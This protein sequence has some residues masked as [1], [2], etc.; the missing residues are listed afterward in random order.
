M[1]LYFCVFQ[2]NLPVSFKFHCFNLKT[3]T[4]FIFKTYN[5]CPVLE[6]NSPCKNIFLLVFGKLHFSLSGKMKIQIS[7][8]PSAVATLY[9]QSS[10][11][12]SSLVPVNEIW[13]GYDW[14][15]MTHKIIGNRHFYPTTIE[16]KQ[17][18]ETNRPILKILLWPFSFTACF[19]FLF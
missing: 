4:P 5:I 6:V 2:T 18:G 8:F 1:N 13:T 19:H 11:I 16:N 15:N 12:L 17:K 14:P 7:C 9:Q 10:N 3:S